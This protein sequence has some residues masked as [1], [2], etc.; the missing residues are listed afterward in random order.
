MGGRRS[1]A[2]RRITSRK[3]VFNPD[4]ATRVKH[5]RMGVWDLYEEK[6]PELDR[7]PGL[8]RL[9]KFLSLKQTLP[10]IWRMVK[11][12]SGIRGCGLLLLSYLV[13]ELLMALV[14]AAVLW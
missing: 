2:T 3:G 14:P 1:R 13:I 12:I 6:Q 4:D 7:V 9:E 11:D 10:Y 5:T 8:S